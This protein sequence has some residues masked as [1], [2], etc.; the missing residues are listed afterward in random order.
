MELSSLF[1]KAY[2]QFGMDNG[3]DENNVICS[4]SASKI[5]ARGIMELEVVMFVV[6]NV[7]S[8]KFL[9]LET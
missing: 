4:P 3:V 5:L 8:Y 2:Y 7:N 1:F 9:I 6:L